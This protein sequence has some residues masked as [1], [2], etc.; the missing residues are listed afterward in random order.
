MTAKEL[1][2]HAQRLALHTHEL[3]LRIE[4]ARTQAGPHGQQLG[5]I[6]GSGGGDPMRPIDNIVDAGAA[7]ELDRLK[8]RRDAMFERCTAILYGHDGRGGLA[9]AR[10]TIDADILCCH[11]LGCMSWRQIAHEV[12][13]PDSEEPRRWCMMR[14]RR[15]LDYIDRVGVDYLSDL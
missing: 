2:E 5:S 15:A 12:I 10:C 3:E 1:F 6:G 4:E 9:K 7:E 11:Y 14:A 8:V 13:K